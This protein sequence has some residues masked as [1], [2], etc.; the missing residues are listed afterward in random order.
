MKD[1]SCVGYVRVSTEEQALGGVSIVAQEER[2]RG[3]AIAT[4][5]T[6]ESIVVD[7][8]ESAKNLRR[9]GAKSLIDGVISGRISTVVIVKLDRLTRSVRDLADLLDLF[10]RKNVALAS[11]NENLD[12]S[13]AGGRLM[14]NLLVSVSQWEREAIGER[15]AFALAH[16]RLHRQVY[17]HVPFGYRKVGSNILQD[18]DEQAA[19]TA[20][21]RMRIQG[22]SF[23]SIARY[24]TESGLATSQGARRWTRASVRQ[25]LSS[26]IALESG[27]FAN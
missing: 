6:L 25:V 12:T 22:C 19:I 7:A 15:T 18:P 20:A 4:E 1:R 2:I 21:R 11:V 27:L 16:K 26:R 9:P 3:F 13:T 14:L 17:G 5:R 24:F 10:E 8:G 23:D